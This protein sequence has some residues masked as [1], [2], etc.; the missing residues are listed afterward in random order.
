MLRSRKFFQRGSHFDYVFLVDE[1]RE[2]S[3]T[4][5]SGPSSVRQRNAI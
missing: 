3:N 5:I 1:G 2:D 4:T